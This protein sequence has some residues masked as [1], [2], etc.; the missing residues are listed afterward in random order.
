MTGMLQTIEGPHGRFTR[1]ENGLIYFYKSD[2][3]TIDKAAALEYLTSIRA[4]DDSGTARLIVVQGHQVEYTFDAQYTLLTNTLLSGLAF[5]TKT[6]PQF[7]TAELLKE[8]ARAFKAR[9]PVSIFE[10]IEEAE[11]WLLAQGE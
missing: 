4:L 10:S 8:L 5:V 11:A 2:N 7:L 3:V 1:Q 9:Y 6:N